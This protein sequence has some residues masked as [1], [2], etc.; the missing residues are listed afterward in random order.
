[1]AYQSQYLIIE[2]VSISVDGQFAKV[3]EKHLSSL[4]SY[5]E[6]TFEDSINQQQTHLPME[7]VQKFSDIVS[8]KAY[9]LRVEES[10]SGAISEKEFQNWELEAK[11]WK[12]VG[13]LYNIRL[14][15]NEFEQNGQL[16]EL[17]SIFKWLQSC[18]PTSSLTDDAKDECTLQKWSN[19]K[20]SIINARYKALAG[21]DTKDDLVEDLDVDA[22]LRSNKKIESADEQIDSK[23]FEIIYDLVL[24]GE[25]KEAIDHAK[26][27][28]NFALA[29]ILVGALDEDKEEMVDQIK[30][31][32][33]KS[34]WT[35]LVY[36]LSQNPK[37]GHYEKLIYAYLSGGDISENLDRASR[38]YEEYLNVLIN[39]LI[40]YLSLEK[41]EH[42][43]FENID[44]PP[45]QAK[46]I[47]DILNIVAAADG[48]KAKEES[49]HPIRIITASV[50]IKEIDLLIQNVD[51][52]TDGNII[53]IITHLAIFLALVQ[54]SQNP[55]QLS[56]LITLYI[57]KLS[58]SNQ[59]ELIPLYLSFIPDERDARET[60]SLILSSITDKEKRAKQLQIAKR[61]A[62]PQVDDDTMIVA[63]DTPKEMLD[64]VLRRTVERVM[65][66]TAPYYQ[67]SDGAIVVSDDDVED[68]VSEVDIRLCDAVEWFYDNRMFE[69]A[70]NS[71]IV[72]IRRFL[73]MGK[74]SSLKRFAEGKNFKN[75]V[76]EYNL[77]HT[78]D[79]SEE[80]SEDTK[81][82]LINYENFVEG[83]RLLSQW[84][85]FVAEKRTYDGSNVETSLNKTSKTMT[86]LASEWLKDL[87]DPILVEFRSLYVPYMIIELITV[88][89]NARQKD[90]K[91]IK[92]AFGLVNQVAN[93][94]ANDFLKCFTSSGRLQEFLVKIGQLSA[95]ASERGLDGLY[96]L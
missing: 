34:T 73:M 9:D 3:L 20:R 41:E 62:S 2:D 49:A 59:A 14:Y 52:E 11:L 85:K 53:R 44:I 81:H 27:T 24:E 13:E 78:G 47:R 43:S 56:A 16:E 40:I 57:S 82:E 74:L 92:L 88:Y 25:I 84:R 54:P 51:A 75:L 86:A 95:I 48:T 5:E 76:S 36:N 37:L 38:S 64:N 32:Y 70:I 19:T 1:M 66:E 89:E 87:S 6:T 18:T 29:L 94:G 21:D 68:A 80:V 28:D 61:I 58:E 35:K 33:V 46:S 39:Q 31:S 72:V 93:D 60:Y 79:E 65:N 69:D 26:D 4:K 30:P 10:H 96:C 90:W 83:L 67:P 45:P 17:E 55:D 42:A 22:P 63:D 71:T 91:Y 15:G 12:L 23:N 50:M 8:Q 7:I 77:Q